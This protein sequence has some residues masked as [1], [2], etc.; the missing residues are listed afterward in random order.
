M[1]MILGVAI[2]L[3]MILFFNIIITVE[4]TSFGWS[5]FLGGGREDQG[6]GIDVDKNGCVYVIGATKSLDF[7]VTLGAYDTVYYDPSDHDDVFVAKL[8]PSGR[9]LH[10]ATYLGGMGSDIGF[11]IFVDATGNAYLTGSTNSTDFPTTSGAFDPAGYI[12]PPNYSLDAFVAVLNTAG[13]NLL[14]GTYLG[15]GSQDV[16]LGIALDD[17]GHIH[18]SGT[19][20]SPYFPTTPGAFME[21]SGGGA[22]DGFVTKFTTDGSDLAYSTFLGGTA[23]DYGYEMVIDE[24]GQAVVSGYTGSSDFPATT[25]AYDISHNGGVLDAFLTKLNVSGSNLVFS[26]FVGGSD[27]DASLGLARDNIGNLFIIGGTTS[28]DFPITGAAFDPIYNGGPGDVF[29]AEIDPTGSTLLYGSYLGGSGIDDAY[30]IQVDEYG[31]IHIAGYTGSTDFPITPGAFDTSYNGDETDAFIA[32]LSSSGSSLEYATYLGGESSDYCYE[33]VLD[34]AGIAHV[35]GKTYS[36]DFFTSSM[37]FDG[38]HNGDWD[39][40]VTKLDSLGQPVPVALVSFQATGGEGFITLDWTTASEINCHRWQI[41]RRD[42]SGA[43]FTVIGEVPGRGSAETPEDYRWSD[44]RVR[45]GITYHYRLKQVDS[46]GCEWWSQVV[47][48]TAGCNVPKGFT[49][50]QNHPNPFNARTSIRYTIPTALH[51]SLKVYN[52]LGEEVRTL[53]DTKQQASTYQV[54][55]DGRDGNSR[56]VASG[57]YFCRLKAGDHSYGIKMEYLK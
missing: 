49:L 7:P 12:A 57:V 31:D 37:P 29:I 26:T 38:T 28:A 27:S 15:H 19:T 10:F 4:A 3:S 47:S 11:D 33:I 45:P 53:V 20:W 8:S 48:A 56:Q 40:F 21:T 46:G 55:W 9:D 41:Y 52:I 6:W 34:D 14:Y 2:I 42:H 1:R 50:C 22:C 24:N 36:A 23:E 39:A 54:T 35:V 44:R 18:V 51:V 25:G 43:E 30:G 16:A 32:K 13:D 5:T 17:S